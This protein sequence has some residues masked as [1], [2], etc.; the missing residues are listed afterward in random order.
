MSDLYIK[1]I[2]GTVTFL[3]GA[4]S[5][6]FTIGALPAGCRMTAIK[7]LVTVANDAGTSAVVEIGTSD[8]ADKYEDAIDVTSAGDIA[9]TMLTPAE[10]TADEEIIA[11]LTEVGTASTAGTAI[12]VIE[13]IQN[14]FS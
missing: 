14:D 3:G 9:T 10:P 4:G 8:D 12:I 1:Q 5:S 7:A 11:T 6:T 2:S 13:Y